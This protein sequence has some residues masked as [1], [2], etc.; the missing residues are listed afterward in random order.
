MAFQGV[1]SASVSYGTVCIRY[2]CRRLLPREGGKSHHWEELLPVALLAVN[3]VNVRF[4][5]I[6]A[7]RDV[8]L[9]VEAGQITG[10]IGPN[11]AGKTTL[12][13]VITGVQPPTAGTVTF[14]GEDIS[15][16]PTHKRAR[17]GDPGHFP[18]LPGV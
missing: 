5:G 10:L 13:N 2:S 14:D 18:P 3:D 17:R 11:G 7:V 4:G 9:A 6:H 15:A 16:L 1:M 8:N 12:F